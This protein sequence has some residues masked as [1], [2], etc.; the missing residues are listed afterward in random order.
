MMWSTQL[1]GPIQCD[2]V[3]PV[4]S[5]YSG[6]CVYHVISL[7]IMKDEQARRHNIPA[8]WPCQYLDE[9]KPAAE[10]LCP[11][12]KQTKMEDG[13]STASLENKKLFT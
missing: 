5:M 9:K 10:Q 3:S 4:R 13:W 2:V 7:T 12:W 1:A 6:V 8:P 11:G